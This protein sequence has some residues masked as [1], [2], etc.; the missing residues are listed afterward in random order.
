MNEP[1]KM[2]YFGATPTMMTM[3]EDVAEVTG[4]SRQTIFQNAIYEYYQLVKGKTPSQ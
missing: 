2:I 3:I 1:K 4:F